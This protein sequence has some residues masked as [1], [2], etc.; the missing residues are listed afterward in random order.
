M[1][2]SFSVTRC[3]PTHLLP[4]LINNFYSGKNLPEYLG[5]F[6]NVKKLPNLKNL[7]EAKFSQLGHPESIADFAK[8]VLKRNLD[9]N[10]ILVHSGFVALASL[11]NC[12][13][14]NVD[15]TI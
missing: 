9:P 4:K 7:P 2:H 5:H 1:P 13:H 12:Q 8:M 11:P 6:C 3:Y 14:Q 15:I 10:N